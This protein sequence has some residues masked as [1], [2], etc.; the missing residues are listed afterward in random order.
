MLSRSSR[1]IGEIKDDDG[2]S[3]IHAAKLKMVDMENKACQ[4]NTL[5]SNQFSI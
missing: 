3:N 5:G 1:V 4:Q 2:F